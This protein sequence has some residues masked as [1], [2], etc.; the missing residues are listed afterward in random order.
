MWN[1]DRPSFDGRFF[2]FSGVDAQ[3]RP[4]QAGGPPVIV[5][6]SSDAALRRAV[7]YGKGWYGFAM[8][9]SQ[10]EAVVQRLHKLDGGTDLEISV[11]PNTRIDAELV[12]DFQQ[13]GV[14]R[15]ISLMPQD[16]SRVKALIDDL[17]VFQ[18]RS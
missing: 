12:T 8:S 7:K 16:E 18:Q 3:P 15:L 14:H 9:V 4:V 2:Q 10:A 11:T 5:G 17:V 1:A 6:G 13:I